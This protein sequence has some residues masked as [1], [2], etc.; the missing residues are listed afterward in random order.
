MEPER[1]CGHLHARG[2][3]RLSDM[4]VERGAYGP[5]NNVS[6]RFRTSPTALRIALGWADVK[7]PSKGIRA[8]LRLG[9]SYQKM[10]VTVNGG[11]FLLSPSEDEQVCNHSAI[12]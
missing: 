12:G 10:F 11:A 1:D 2:Y 9:K 6:R 4:Q 7:L 3:S 8:V 5:A